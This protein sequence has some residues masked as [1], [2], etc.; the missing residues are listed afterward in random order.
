MKSLSV[1]LLILTLSAH[2][3]QF[4]FRDGTFL[5][6]DIYGRES[7]G[8]SPDGITLHQRGMI[9]FHHYP[10]TSESYAPP[11]HVSASNP[12][13]L[14]SCVPSRIAFVHFSRGTLLALRQDYAR[15]AN[16][17]QPPPPVPASQGHSIL[18]G[19]VPAAPT[20]SPTHPAG[21]NL[22]DVQMTARSIITGIDQALGEQT[23]RRPDASPMATQ[24]WQLLVE[25]EMDAHFG[26]TAVWGKHF[27]RPL[28]P[29]FRR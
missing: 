12:N 16:I 14:P 11:T 20:L 26:R 23:R 9:Y 5:E 7:F 29:S 10:S 8:P 2:A 22:T 27:V 3:R 17:P 15:V 1:V 25:L 19:Q 13:Y 21:A 18:Y 28:T 24:Q 6:A 4:V